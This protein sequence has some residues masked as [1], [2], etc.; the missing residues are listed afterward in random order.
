MTVLNSVITTN[1]N[2]LTVRIGDDVRV[3]VVYP[4]SVSRRWTRPGI[5]SVSSAAYALLSSVD[6]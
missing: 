6:L 2:I 3:I 4:R 5:L 1:I